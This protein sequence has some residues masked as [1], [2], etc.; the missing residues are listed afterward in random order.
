MTELLPWNSDLWARFDRAR[1]SGKLSHAILLQGPAGLGKVGFARLVVQALLC[2]QP[3]EAGLPCTVCRRC[4]QVMAGSHPDVRT[5]EPEPDRK[6]IRVEQAR[7][8]IDFLDLTSQYAGYKIAL[9]S[10]AERLTIPAANCLL[11]TLEEPPAGT[12]LVLVTDAPA[13]LPVTLRSRCQTVSFR[14][15]DR[16]Q[17]EVWLA[18]RVEHD[19]AETTLALCLGGGAPLTALRFLAADSREQYAGLIACFIDIGQG[20]LDPVAAA[21]EWEKTDLVFFLGLLSSWYTDLMRLKIHPGGSPL[22]HP[23]RTREIRNLS[24]RV[25]A[26]RLSDCHRAAQLTLELCDTGLAQRLM[27][28]QSLLNLSALFDPAG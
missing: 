26:E 23:D 28:E 16:R 10:P 2:E 20:R 27:V 11:K 3:A 4:R 6:T 25:N 1:A 24:A 21:A 5:V 18:D 7:A 14:L 8:L 15:P 12:V 13:R 17:A 22:Y 19:V 9:I